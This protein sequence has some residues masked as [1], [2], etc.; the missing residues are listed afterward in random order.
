MVLPAPLNV[1][2][3]RL[4]GGAATPAETHVALSSQ[5]FAVPGSPE[6]RVRDHVVRFDFGDRLEPYRALLERIAPLGLACAPEVLGV[7]PGVEAALLTRYPAADGEDLVRVTDDRSPV[8]AASRERLRQDLVALQGAGLC[9]PYA[10]R[11]VT[12]WLRS[13]TSGV[14]LLDAWQAARPWTPPDDENW[15]GLDRALRSLG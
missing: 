9:H 2:W 3:A 14:L 10:H 6:V 1:A 15:A 11:G 13:R 4:V 7:V 12:H 5:G 8:Q